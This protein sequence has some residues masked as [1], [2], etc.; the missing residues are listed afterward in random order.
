MLKVT[1]KYIL[2]FPKEREKDVLELMEQTEDI[3]VIENKN[4]QAL[5]E[6]EK[7]L[8]ALQELDYL[9]SSFGF[10]IS[11]L[12]PFAKK[13]SLAEKI[14]NPRIIVKK[15]SIKDEKEKN[16]LVSLVE[17]TVEIEKELETLKREQK[18]NET[19]LTGL[20]NF[21][22]LD[23]APKDTNH[24][25]FLVVSVP[26][27]QLEGF[28]SA[29]FKNKFYQRELHRDSSKVFCLVVGLKEGEKIEGKEKFL[30][31]LKDFKA[32]TVPFG[33]SNPPSEERK[34][35]LQEIKEGKVKINGFKKELS[36]AAQNL[37]DLKTYYDLLNIQKVQL[38]IKKRCLEEGFLSYLLFWAT[39][40]KKKELEGGLKKLSAELIIVETAPEKDEL[41]PVILE[42][43]KVVQPF[44]YVTEIF[45]LP[46]NDEIDP[47]P[48]LA[49]FFIL[50]FGIC[51]TDAAYGLLIALFTGFSLLFLKGLF[52]DTKLL[53][54]LFYGGISTMIMG[55]LFGSY[56]GA[57]PSALRLSFLEKLKLIDPIKDTTLFMGLAFFLGYLQLVFAQA[58]RIISGRRNKNKGLF[59]AGIAWM[60]LYLAGGVLLLGLKWPLLKQIGLWPVLF[61]V[62]LV[63]FV[64]S[65]GVKIFL[66]PLAGAIKMLQGLI[67][68]MSDILSYSRLMALGLAT[69]VI[70]LIVNQIALLFGEMIPY[71]GWLVAGLILIGG[72]IFNL[73]INALGAFIHSGRLQFVEF[74]PK[75]LEGGGRRLKSIKSKLKYIKVE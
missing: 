37:R 65:R 36:K 14:K 44:Q 59:L 16:G 31:H 22:N 70:A 66:R 21:G 11:Y 57:S 53:K 12:K 48:Y 61:S 71:V 46:R 42:N 15:K 32:E 13:I 41:P 58:V 6:K 68:T 51:L 28:L 33:F 17:R 24:T 60:T 38:E 49:F 62:L 72:H 63:L 34:I 3:E 52:S 67:G 2:A 35:I 4:S 43:N 55:I 47:T 23:F 75:F 19:K 20:A 56:F 73:G 69:A 25:F 8:R 29:C 40:E 74:F 10:A 54:L 39:E 9:I 27:P 50:F 1:K 45:G 30:E 64:E 7:I 5:K 26:F 18:E